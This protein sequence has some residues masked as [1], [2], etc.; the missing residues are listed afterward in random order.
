MNVHDPRDTFT[1]AQTSTQPTEPQWL[2]DT[3]CCHTA[4][5]PEGRRHLTTLLM[6]A[7]KNGFADPAALQDFLFKN[8]D[9]VKLASEL[10]TCASPTPAGRRFGQLFPLEAI[11]AYRM[12]DEGNNPLP[13]AKSRVCEATAHTVEIPW[14]DVA[15]NLAARHDYVEYI[16]IP[17]ARSHVVEALECAISPGE[18]SVITG[19]DI[20]ELC[21][22]V[23][24]LTANSAIPDP[25]A[26]GGFV[27]F[28]QHLDAFPC[29]QSPNPD[30]VPPPHAQ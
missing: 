5:L 10:L 2:P 11:D 3:S 24:A 1:P 9:V 13:G 17:A 26:A 28:F 21:A 18:L 27:D 4:S 12:Q 30:P 25:P 20:Q 16:L 23:R 29:F 19:G 14:N 8:R 7:G 22:L 15:C 6:L